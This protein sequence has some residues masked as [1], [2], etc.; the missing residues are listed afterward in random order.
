MRAHP[1]TPPHSSPFCVVALVSPRYKK[2]VKHFSDAISWDTANHVYFSNRSAAQIYCGKF[3]S[4][5]RDA[6][7]CVQL[8]P[9]WAKGYSRLGTAQFYLQNY[10]AAI[11]ALKQGLALEADNEGMQTM[12]TK[13]EGLYVEQQARDAEKKVRERY[14]HNTARRQAR[15]QRAHTTRTHASARVFA[16]S[17]PFAPR[18]VHPAVSPVPLQPRH[19][20]CVA[21]S[22]G[23][24]WASTAYTS[25]RAS[26]AAPAPRRPFPALREAGGARASLRARVADGDGRAAGLIARARA[27]RHWRVGARAVSAARTVRSTTLPPPVSK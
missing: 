20:S 10:L 19:V 15:R 24:P 23:G 12:L 26:P 17:H 3:K 18:H 7:K 27:F 5:L 2:A 14:D 4:A 25:R 6:L 11:S 21:W 13:S 16:R 8:Q 9:G 1:L 22:L